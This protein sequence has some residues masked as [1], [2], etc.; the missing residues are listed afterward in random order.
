M[1]NAEGMSHK[2]AID[3]ARESLLHDEFDIDKTKLV[4]KSV[5][6]RAGDF[7]YVEASYK[8]KRNK[9]TNIDL[10][11]DKIKGKVIKVYK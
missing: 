2:G 11:I 1:Y 8:N 4:V 5:T 7:W 9:V 10:Y 6:N 3:I